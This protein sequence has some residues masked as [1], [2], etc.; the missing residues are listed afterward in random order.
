MTPFHKPQK[1]DHPY[2]AHI[3]AFKRILTYALMTGE[4][5]TNALWRIFFWLLLF[6][7]LW[8]MEI[9]DLFALKGY[10]AA[11]ILF[12]AGILYFLWKDLL[13]FSLPSL[14]DVDRRIEQDSRLKHR[15]LSEM[16]DR[17]V[18]VRGPDT[19]RLWELEQNRRQKELS[20]AQPGRWRSF[21]SAKDRHGLRLMAVII[22]IAGFMMAGADWQGR[23][24]QGLFPLDWK[25]NYSEVPPMVATITPPEYTKKAQVVLQGGGDI[26]NKI[27]IPSG[28]TIKVIMQDSFA[29]PY[30][31]DGTQK[32]ALNPI[33]N[34]GYE[35]QWT[36]DAADNAEPQERRLDVKQFFISRFGFDYTL[37]PD[38]PPRIALQEK[39]PDAEDENKETAPNQELDAQKNALENEPDNIE[40]NATDKEMAETSLQKEPL[41]LPD[42][43]IQIPLNLY[44][45]YG[46]KTIT[47]HMRLDDI[48]EEAPLGYEVRQTRSVMSPPDQEFQLAP[49]FDF[50]DNPWA[51]LPVT[52]DIT[53][54]D[55]LGQ[56]AKLDTISMPLPEREF[57]HPM[58]QKLIALRKQLAWEP[59]NAAISVHDGLVEIL[60]YPQDFQDDEIVYLSLS[61]AASR[62]KHSVIRKNG[63][64]IKD[65]KS[66]MDLLWNTALRIEDGNLSIAARNL[67]QAQM[68]LENALQ[69]PD[70]TNEQIASLMNELRLAMGDYLTE[71]KKELQKR[72]AQGEELLLTP[73]M[74]DELLDP[75]SLAGFLSQMEN[76]MLE[77]NTD[78]AQGMLSQL[79]RML[80]MLN[81]NMALPM[82][83]NMM[84]MMDGVSEL[85]QLIDKQEE[86]LV[87]TEE[88]KE[89]QDRFITDRHF[90]E[91]L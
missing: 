51:G 82:P 34:G 15:P 27:D 60:E 21:L 63:G 18:S 19:M 69:N 7:G 14:A 49:T 74:L 62:L 84:A 23:L 41:V 70:M 87:Q 13:S 77:G 43:Q 32:L 52:I 67:R 61:T 78:T 31:L 22:F 30:I 72:F 80:D 20:H 24:I 53:A 39:E 79:Q 75:E 38:T 76:E 86:L 88:Q 11:S 36:L 68:E 25:G 5:F 40:D 28:S 47:M 29:S 55:H 65:V 91:L 54:T 46:V 73:E 8:L 59:R 57:K 85:Q 1:K 89:L 64:D 50:T 48:V 17:P 83:E 12:I 71:F 2:A 42:A 44:D 66:V 33:E 35:A 9:P 37:I 3:L 6:C 26:K 10:Y 81:P 45:D 4:Q 56:T 58:A 16:Q 90:G